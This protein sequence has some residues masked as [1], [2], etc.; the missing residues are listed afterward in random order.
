MS[1]PPDG[2]TRPWMIV[3]LLRQHSL[4]LAIAD[5]PLP[6]LLGKRGKRGGEHH[7]GRQQAGDPGRVHGILG[8]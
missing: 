4:F 2:V 7:T 6:R 1:V 5:P 3:A 8:Y